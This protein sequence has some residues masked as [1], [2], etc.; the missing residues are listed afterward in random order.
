MALKDF[1]ANDFETRDNHE[2]SE[3][4]TH[5]YRA[6]YEDAKDAV[7]RV[8]KSKQMHV[9]SVDDA[10]KEVYLQASNHHLILV[11]VNP[12]PAETAIDM[13][14]TTYQVIGMKRGI[15]IIMEFYKEL[16]KQLTFKGVGLYR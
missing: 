2:M 3:L 4:R 11:L 12:N 1:F 16:D 8:A 10:H 5:Y 13:K 9:R 14:V 6:R 7:I 15:K